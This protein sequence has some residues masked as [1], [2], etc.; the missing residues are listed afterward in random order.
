MLEKM[1]DM[2]RR[3]E[4]FEG[5]DG[6]QR[7]AGEDVVNFLA[8]WEEAWSKCKQ[9]GVFIVFFIWQRQWNQTQ[10]K[11]A[12]WSKCKQTGTVAILHVSK[13][14][15]KYK[16]NENRREQRKQTE[17]MKTDKDKGILVQKQ[18]DPFT[19]A[20]HTVVNLVINMGAASWFKCMQ[21]H[22]TAALHP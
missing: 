6:C 5:F 17:T 16:D 15:I 9:T 1:T 10:T 4:A 18:A 21:T 22:V 3:L 13:T 8:R 20:I 11:E 7:G 2:K 19:N 14:K 12:G